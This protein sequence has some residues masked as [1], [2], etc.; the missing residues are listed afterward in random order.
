MMRRLATPIVLVVLAVSCGSDDGGS[1]G[2][3]GE[4]SVP[5]STYPPT[6]TEGLAAVYDEMLEPLGLR[7]TRGALIDRSGGGY[8][9]SATGEHLALYVEPLDDSEY[10]VEDYIEAIGTVTALVTPQVFDTWAG[11]ESYDICQEPPTA[12]DARDE[13]APYTQIE[14]T[15]EESDRVDWDSATAETVIGLGLEGKARVV[16]TPVIRE[17]PRYE[18]AQTAA[19]A[20][21][22]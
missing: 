3:A 13:P 5:A 15:R 2:G 18:A 19:I 22:D 10:A 7:F 20:T 4:A 14:I 21:G 17:H 8:V 9:P 16:V 1:V 6:S 11:V 12:V